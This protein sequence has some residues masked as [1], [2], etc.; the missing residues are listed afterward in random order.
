M[1]S[2]DLSIAYSHY[3]LLKPEKYRLDGVC[4]WVLHTKQHAFWSLAIVCRTMKRNSIGVLLGR[5]ISD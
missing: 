4:S 1:I 2:Y 5:R 3:C